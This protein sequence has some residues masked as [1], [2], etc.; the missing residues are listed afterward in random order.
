MTTARF[1]HPDGTVDHVAID[2]R[3]SLM[4]AAVAQ[5]VTGI[6]GECGGRAMCATCHVHVWADQANR[7]PEMT[8]DEDEMLDAVC[9]QRIEGRSRLACQL[10]AGTD[11]DDIDV[12]VPSG[13]TS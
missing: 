9:D 8:E 1:H 13:T 4:K 7:L 3:E 2:P 12:D 6:I 5:S 10:T 11:F